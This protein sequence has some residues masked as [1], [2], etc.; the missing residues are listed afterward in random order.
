MWKQLKQLPKSLSA[1]LLLILLLLLA[2]L[3][4]AAIDFFHDRN[5][6][7]QAQQA[8]DRDRSL[9]RVLLPCDPQLLKSWGYVYCFGRNEP[10]VGCF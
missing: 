8:Y 4:I 3:S 10:P 7:V 1:F 2:G 9:G 5:L 6:R